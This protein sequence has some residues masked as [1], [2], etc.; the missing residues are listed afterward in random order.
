MEETIIAAASFK[1][2]KCSTVTGF[3]QFRQEHFDGSVRVTILLRGLSDGNHGIHV[4]DN[5]IGNL[6][7]LENC[8]ALLGG[9]FSVATAFSESTPNGVPHGSYLNRGLRH[10]GDLCNNIYSTNGVASYEYDDELISL[11]NGHPANI[12]GR[13]V[14]VH[15]NMD[16]CGFGD[17]NLSKITGNS[18]ARLGCADI[19]YFSAIY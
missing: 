3:V 6:P 8:C 17:N 11:I 10:T 7:D 15:E 13:S 4:H 9:H 14:V 19:K 5:S 16:D 12:V 1:L 2:S 18:G